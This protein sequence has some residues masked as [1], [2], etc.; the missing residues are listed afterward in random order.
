MGSES[1]LESAIIR[2]FPHPE[3]PLLLVIHYQY[4]FRVT[5]RQ[6]AALNKVE[7]SVWTKMW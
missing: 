1:G 3:P 2:S 6:V 7:Q 4:F 5:G